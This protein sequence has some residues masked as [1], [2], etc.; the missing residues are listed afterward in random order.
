[1][2]DAKLLK[3]Y[4][5]QFCQA[6]IKSWEEPQY[7]VTRHLARTFSEIYSASATEPVL[8]FLLEVNLC[9]YSN[10]LVLRVLKQGK[11]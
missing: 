4:Y 5:S 2:Y 10:S 11:I 3:G 8:S 6:I 1:M 9:R 7:R